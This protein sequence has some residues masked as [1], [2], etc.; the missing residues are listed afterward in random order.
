MYSSYYCVYFVQFLPIT[1]KDVSSNLAHGDMYSI[2]VKWLV[3]GPWFS[4]GAP[5]S[6]NYKTDRHDITEMLLK[7]AINTTDLTLTLTL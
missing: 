3:V 4:S 7:V 5:V 2:H 1:N 6:S